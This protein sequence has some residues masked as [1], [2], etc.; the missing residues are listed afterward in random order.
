[1]VLAEV[2]SRATNCLGRRGHN[3]KPQNP[4]LHRTAGSDIRTVKRQSVLR[5]G[6]R[7][8]ND[9]NDMRAL[10]V[11]AIAWLGNAGPQ[12]EPAILFHLRG[13]LRGCIVLVPILV[14]IYA[15]FCALV[16]LYERLRYGHILPVIPRPPAPPPSDPTARFTS[17]KGCFCSTPGTRIF[18]C[19]T[20]GRV[21][22]DVCASNCALDCLTANPRCDWLGRVG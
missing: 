11:F 4:R 13:A 17:C 12:G 6:V 9:H 15:V 21:Y 19:C 20:C 16:Y 3:G 7:C 14:L 5:L 1:M 22:C 10:V 8:G 2:C 18:Q